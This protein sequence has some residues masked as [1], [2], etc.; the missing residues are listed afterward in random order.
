MQVLH[1][2]NADRIIKQKATKEDWWGKEGLLSQR[3]HYPSENIVLFHASH[4]S[5]L[6]YHE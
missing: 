2:I 3:Y 6:S 5:S 4:F 1:H